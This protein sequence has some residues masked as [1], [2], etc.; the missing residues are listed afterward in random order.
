MIYGNQFEVLSEYVNNETK[1]KL[2]CN[3][4]GSVIEKRPPKMVTSQREGCYICSKKN[5]YK[6]KHILQQEIEIKYPNSFKVLG[7][8]KN[9]KSPLLV[10]KVKCGHVYKVSPDN[11]LRGRGCPR[12]SIRQSHYMD[13]VENYLID[14]K[15]IFEKEK[16]FKDCINIRS[17]H[18]D[19]YIVSMNTCIEV[20]GEFH[21]PK[22]SV[23]LNK[24]GAYEEITKRDKIKTDYCRTN[25][26]RLIRLPFYEEHN[27]QKIL[28]KELYANTEVS[29]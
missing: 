21:F 9:S 10:K 26:I 15:I 13:I 20:D 25:G 24:R 18:F 8:Y 28:D 22:N 19:Y 29:N 23:Y 11:L 3:K 27:F 5:H 16:I 14:H 6:D 17:L 2:K 7:E 12:C 4:C 1:I